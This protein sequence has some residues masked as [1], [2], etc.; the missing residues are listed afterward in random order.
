MFGIG[1]P[2]LV[3]IFIIAL[4]VLGPK[5]LPE[6]AKALGRAFAEFKR[7]TEEIKSSMQDEIQKVAKTTEPLK[8]ITTSIKDDIEK[9]ASVKDS[10]TKLAEAP[11]ESPK[12][13]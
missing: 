3:I 11:A 13:K 9:A 1:I 4:L 10:I 6:I 2:E 8:E 12:K 5:K 7:A